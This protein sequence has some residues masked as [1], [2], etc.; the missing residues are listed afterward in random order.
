VERKKRKKSQTGKTLETGIMEASKLETEWVGSKDLHLEARGKGGKTSSS[1]SKEEVSILQEAGSGKTKKRRGQKGQRNKNRGNGGEYRANTVHPIRVKRRGDTEI[2]K[3]NGEAGD[4]RGGD[5]AQGRT[6][7]PVGQLF[8]PG[9]SGE[10]MHKKGG[11]E[12]QR[13]QKR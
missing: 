7:H 5:A 10:P 9:G 12:H 2:A 3:P 6:Q 4:K 1:R 13:L 11:E 8:A